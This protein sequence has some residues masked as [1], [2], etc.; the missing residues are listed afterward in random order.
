MMP[1]YHLGVDAASISNVF[2]DAGTYT[3]DAGQTAAATSFTANSLAQQRLTLSDPLEEELIILLV[4]V[5]R[6]D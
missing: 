4:K 1:Q 5:A 3:M 6:K 2:G